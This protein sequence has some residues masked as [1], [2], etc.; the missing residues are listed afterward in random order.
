MIMSK[1]GSQRIKERLGIPKRGCLRHIK[2]V[3]ELGDR[4]KDRT[5][6]CIKIMY[7]DFLYIYKM[8]EEGVIFITTYDE[9][10][11][12]ITEYHNKVKE[13]KFSELS[14]P[15]KFGTIFQKN[16]ISK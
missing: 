10:R 3:Y 4:I 9:D 8:T 16:Q 7:Q 2:K 12:K 11:E 1:H 13:K 14:N 15:K 5:D 6:E